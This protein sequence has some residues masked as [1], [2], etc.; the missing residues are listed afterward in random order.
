MPFV[1]ST[2]TNSAYYCEYAKGG[3]DVPV[4]KKKVL[5]KGGAN[6]GGKSLVTPRGVVTEVTQEDLDFLLKN[7]AF[8]RHVKN[9]F[10]TV[11]EQKKQPEAE[12]VA[13]D[14]QPADA[15]APLTDTDYDKGGRQYNGRTEAPAVGKT[16]TKKNGKKDADAE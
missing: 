16:M 12:K 3:A 9:G 1:C 10:L 13:K 4:L 7:D 5:I 2:A 11:V 6:I 8:N 15:S 14:M